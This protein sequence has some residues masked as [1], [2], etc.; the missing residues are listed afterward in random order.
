MRQSSIPPD[1]PTKITPARF[2]CSAIT[3]I[4][5]DYRQKLSRTIGNSDGLRKR[6]L[7]IEEGLRKQNTAI[8]GNLAHFE[9]WFRRVFRRPF[10]GGGILTSPLP[11]L[12]VALGT[13]DFDGTSL[14]PSSILQYLGSDDVYYHLWVAA[15]STVDECPGGK[16]DERRVTRTALERF[17]G[18]VLL[19]VVNKS[20]TD[21][22]REQLVELASALIDRV[23][24]PHF[25]FADPRLFNDVSAMVRNACRLSKLF[26]ERGICKS[27]LIV[28]IPATEMGIL[29][30]KELAGHGLHTN[31]YLVCDHLHAAA[32]VEAEASAVTI[33]IGMILDWYERKRKAVLS[34]NIEVH[35]GIE[36]IQSIVA[37]FKQ[38]RL[39]TRVIGTAFR[40]LPEIGPLGTL[41]AVCLSKAQV[42]QMK[43]SKV[44]ILSIRETSPAFLRARETEHPTSFL[45]SKLG[46]ISSLPLATREKLFGTVYMALGALKANMETIESLVRYEVTRQYQVKAVDL[47]TLYRTQGPKTPT[48]QNKE[49]CPQLLD[50]PNVKPMPIRVESARSGL[51][52]SIE[53][54]SLGVELPLEDQVF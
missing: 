39:N 18:T 6:S 50:K 8:I 36:S 29:A 24:G 48:K 33:D 37:Y 20:L 34:P 51:S 1:P 9:S 15:Q 41:D 46:V 44:P 38:H 21:I 10:V 30:A 25:T 17:V 40:T 16:F 14:T 5:S 13:F 4:D 28:S 45:N 52:C 22:S 54:R 12:F 53:N 26:E 3:T 32:C 31:L 11:A 27:D 42:E 43:W 35:P 2:E 7:G 49:T 47:R 19:P 23:E